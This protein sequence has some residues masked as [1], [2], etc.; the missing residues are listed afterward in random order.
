MPK[1]PFTVTKACPHRWCRP[2]H[3]AI[4]ALGGLAVAILLYRQPMFLVIILVLGVLSTSLY[5]AVTRKS[6]HD[7]AAEDLRPIVPLTVRPGWASTAVTLDIF[8]LVAGVL[9]LPSMLLTPRD[10]AAGALAASGALPI[11]LLVGASLFHQ[12]AHYLDRKSVV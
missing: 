3:R 11:A 4:T 9:G 10:T 1:T 5:L 2:V 8:I 7:V 6:L 12:L